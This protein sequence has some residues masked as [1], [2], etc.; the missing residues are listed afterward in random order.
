MRVSKDE[1]FLKIAL[2]V[3]SQATCIRRKVGCVLVNHRSHIVATGYNG[4]P[5]GMPHCIEQPCEGAKAPSGT[6]LELCQANH[7]EASALLQCREV[8]EIKTAYVTASPCIHCVKL[9]LN[10][11][12]ERIVF[13]QE[14]PHSISQKRWEDS[15]REWVY[16]PT[17]YPVFLSPEERAPRTV[18]GKQLK[19]YSA[20]ASMRG[21][22]L[23][24][25][26][27]WRERYKNTIYDGMELQ[28]EWKTA[29][30]Y[31]DFY[32]YMGPAPEGTSLDR[33][34]NSRG[35]IKGN[36]R[37]GTLSEQNKNKKNAHIIEAFGRAQNLA[38]WSR[39]TGLSEE[40]ISRRLKVY[41]WSAEKT[42]TEPK[43]YQEK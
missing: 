10:T 31:D 17:G 8:F 21:R 40:C 6:G 27:S 28:E 12:C 25:M 9:L 3:S 4:N 41:K 20:F 15:G 14:Y 24:E 5:P 36:V 18:N 39:E 16:L 32:R 33:I 29:E 7:A 30:G 22:V 13:A 11:S 19:E 43:Q 23:Q 35:Y 34:D 2:H 42:L 37:W 38:D 1:Y 26:P